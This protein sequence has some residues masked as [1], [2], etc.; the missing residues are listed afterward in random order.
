MIG[1]RVLIGGAVKTVEA[2]DPIK[3]GGEI[4]RVELRVRG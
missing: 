1:D 2:A 4:V 3:V